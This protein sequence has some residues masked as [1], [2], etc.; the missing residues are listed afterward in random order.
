MFCLTFVIN[1]G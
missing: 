1:G